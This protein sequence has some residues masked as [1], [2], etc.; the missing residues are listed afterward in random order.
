MLN[1]DF[2]AI[3]D[4][5]LKLP[6]E[7]E[8]KSLVKKLQ[9]AGKNHFEFGINEYDEKL[10][11]DIEKEEKSWDRASKHAGIGNKNRKTKEEAEK[12]I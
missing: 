9:D 8:K 5:K 7:L 12:S 3:Q 10:F 1:K 6:F 11:E 4:G 2:E